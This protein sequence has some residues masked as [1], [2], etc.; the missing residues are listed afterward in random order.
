MGLNT[1]T[2][3]TLW[4]DIAMSEIGVA[5]LHSFSSVGYAIVDHHTLMSEFY[6]W[7]HN[8]MKVRG[9]CPGKVMLL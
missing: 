8:E 4:H 5:I 1:K 9:Y 6:A 3:M 7:Y 2:E